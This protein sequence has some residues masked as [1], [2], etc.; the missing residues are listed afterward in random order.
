MK[1]VDNKTIDNYI[2]GLEI[3][4]REAKEAKKNRMDFILYKEDG[5]TLNV[6]E[7]ICMYENYIAEANSWKKSYF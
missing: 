3:L 1:K 5:N 4:L 7:V 2:K 6:D